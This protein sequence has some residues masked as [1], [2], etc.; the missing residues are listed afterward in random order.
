MII[1]KC[2]THRGKSKLV[3]ELKPSSMHK[4]EVQC[5]NCKNIRT[6]HYRSIVTA[7]HHICQAC[8][9]KYQAKT[10]T[11][12]DR[13]GKVV[14][15]GASARSGSSICLCDCGTTTEI[16]NRN[17]VNGITKSCGCLKQG[18]FDN[19]NRPKGCNHGMWKGGVSTERERLAQTKAYKTWQKYVFDRDGHIC[20][21]CKK[22]DRKIN[23]HHIIAFE[24]DVGLRLDVENGV[25]L[26]AECHRRFHK[27]YGRKNISKENLIEFIAS[28]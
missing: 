27:L 24:D 21:C 3:D 7:G 14:V 18:N 6:V 12:G 28:Y 23:T 10:L 16:I 17:L 15:I 2:V 11:V 25:T 8:M 1:T 19:A 9:M 22:P 5:P 13:Y 20:Q 4:V 26:C